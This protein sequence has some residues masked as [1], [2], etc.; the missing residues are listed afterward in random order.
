MLAI[1]GSFTFFIGESFNLGA[2]RLNLGV[3]YTSPNYELD[4]IAEET[5]TIRKANETSSFMFRNGL[6][7]IF[8]FFGPP[9]AAICFA[10]TYIQQIKNNKAK[11]LKNTILLK[12][13]I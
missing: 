10:R 2:D 9:F 13:R 5:T 8:L 3:Y 7:R 11:D 1:V 4:W 6:V 12:L